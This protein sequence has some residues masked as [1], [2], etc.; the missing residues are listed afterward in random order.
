MLNEEHDAAVAARAPP[1]PKQIGGSVRCADAG[2]A[3]FDRACDRREIRAQ[4]CASRVW[5]AEL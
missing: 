1:D 3:S 4:A 2:I 5:I